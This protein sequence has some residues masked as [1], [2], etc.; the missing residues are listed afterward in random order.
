M[1]ALSTLPDASIYGNQEAPKGTSLRDVLDLS[2][3]NIALQKEKALLPS[4]IETGQA[5]A[6]KSTVEA[7]KAQTG[8]D[9]DFANK[10]RQEQIALIN[11]P[12]IVQAEQDPQF[13]A[14]NKDKILNLVNGQA[15]SAQNLGLDPQ[16]A[17]EL[18][19]P[20][21]EAVNQ[22]NGQGL[23]QFLKTRM[24][25]G[26]DQQAQ[27]NLNPESYFQAAPAA[28]AAPAVQPGGAPTEE[29]SKPEK[30]S[31][32]PPVAGQPRSELPSEAGDRAFGEK[33]RQSLSE[34]Q[35]SY[36]AIRQNY[37]KLIDQTEKVAGSTFFGGAAGTAERALKAKIGTPEYQQLS[38]D[39]AKAQIAQIEASG[40][41]LSTDAGKS[42]AA[43]ANGTVVY[44][45]EVLIGIAR[46]NAA[47]IENKNMRANGMR[48][49]SEKNGDANIKHFN[50]MWNKNANDNS[51]FEM[52]YI[53]NRAKTPEQ[54]A[55]EIA[56]Y[57]KESGFSEAKRKELATKYLN[58]QKL[59]TTGSL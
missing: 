25:A 8:L 9:T 54:G 55:K 31:Y 36:G 28:P 13:A 58:L 33:T 1:P 21:L 44:D 40:G 3:S 23:R 5:T 46:R 59:A 51:V 34:F 50:S 37:D 35:N 17:N 15:R 56:A 2:R 32:L 47:E 16:K 6:K 43:H 41:N 22:T 57:I 52:Q 29:F 24:V 4:A 18:N 30:L 38:K 20:Y 45:P 42:L 53:F 14:A 27:A 49:F 11:H 48:I 12:L 26:L 10:M 19:I 39:L 7:I